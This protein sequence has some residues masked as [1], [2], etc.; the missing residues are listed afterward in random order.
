MKFGKLIKYNERNIFLQKSCRKWGSETTSRPRF[1]RG[2]SKWPPAWLQYISIALNLAYSKNKQYKT[3]H[4]WSRDI[5]NFD[6]L[7]KGL[8]ISFPSHFVYDF[9]RKMFLILFS[10]NRPNLLS[11]FPFLLEIL[12]NI[13]ILQL[14]ISRLWHHKI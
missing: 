11:D 5:V 9:S 4:Y 14:F 7:E 2:K 8:G 3:L 6:F 10:I 12:D 1:I 13:Y